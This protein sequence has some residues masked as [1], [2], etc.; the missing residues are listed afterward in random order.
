MQ[1]NPDARPR[2][3]E[4][5]GDQPVPE[6]LGERVDA[7]VE[8]LL[9]GGDPDPRTFE[10]GLP[11]PLRRDLHEALQ[12]ARWVEQTVSA[13]S[14][15]QMER[16][17]LPRADGIRAGAGAGS[18]P[19]E[20]P[21]GQRLGDYEI[22]REVGRGGMGV[23]FEARQ[24][25]LGRR[26]ALKILPPGLGWSPRALE[27][28]RREARAA[29]SLHHPH[30]IPVYDFGEHEG[31]YYFS[32]AFID[33]WSLSSLSRTPE[34]PTLPGRG[35]DG[36]PVRTQ[37]WPPAVPAYATPA[38]FRFVAR[39][40]ADAARAVH[41]AH[42]HGII[43]RDL[44]PS[45]LL[46]DSE[47]QVWIADFGLSR[48]ATDQSVTLSGQ[49]VGTLS[50]MSPEQAASDRPVDQ[51]TDVYGLGATLYELLTLQPPFFARS[52]QEVLRA[53]Q[54]RDPVRPARLNP[55][56]PRDLETITLKALEKDPARRYPSAA[57]LADDLERFLRDLPIRARR[58]GPLRRAAKFLRRQRLVATVALVAAVGLAAAAVAI[59]VALSRKRQAEQQLRIAETVGTQSAQVIA[60][61]GVRDFAEGELSQAEEK[62]QAAAAIVSKLIQV[63]TGT[64]TS[65][66]DLSAVVDATSMA[67][68]FVYQG[69]I[70]LA[71]QTAESQR[72]AAQHFEMALRFVPD[73]LLLRSLK[74]LTA[75]PSYEQ[76]QAIVRQL[77]GPLV[78]HDWGPFAGDAFLALAQVLEHQDLDAARRMVDRA[79]EVDPDNLRAVAYAGWL[80]FRRGDYERA[81]EELRYPCDLQPQN[82]IP[83]L[84]RA[85]VYAAM[86]SFDLALDD[87]EHVLH[88]SPG[89]AQAWYEKLRLIAERAGL[90]PQGGASPATG[91]PPAAR[92]ELL[93]T[94]ERMLEAVRP[95]DFLAY[96]YLGLA[97]RLVDRPGDALAA[98]E[99][100]A[101]LLPDD[102]QGHKAARVWIELGREY[103]AI[104]RE[105][106]A[107]RAFDRALRACPDMDFFL[108]RAR[109]ATSRQ[110]LDLAI[111]DLTEAIRR[112]RRDAPT[113]LERARLL[114]RT[115]R[116]DEALRDIEAALAMDPQASEAYLL[117]SEIRLEQDRLE[118]A[119]TML[120]ALVRHRPERPIG[121]RMR[122][123]AYARLGR[124]AEALADLDA[125]RRFGASS[126]DLLEDRLAVFEALGDTEQA[127]EAAL[128]LYRTDPARVAYL[129]SAARALHRSGRTDE[130]LDLCSR[131]LEQVPNSVPV[132]LLRAEL[133]ASA[134][135]IPEAIDDVLAA[136]E[137]D[138]LDG[139]PRWYAAALLLYGAPPVPGGAERA[140]ALLAQAPPDPRTAAWRALALR[141]AGDLD[142]AIRAA[143]AVRPDHALEVAAV[144]AWHAARSG[145]HDEARAILEQAAAMP[146]ADQPW[147]RRLL[148]DI[149]DD[150]HT[151]DPATPEPDRAGQRAVETNENTQE[152]PS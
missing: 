29:G 117:A 144:R 28:F 133:Y 109:F 128:R 124:R 38:Y 125:A 44:K 99:Q 93:E 102:A 25:S 77:E 50:Y 18:G 139:V 111:H 47:G 98:L 92:N 82:P 94:Y 24:L 97:H 2:P 107:W 51:R 10:A 19:F 142:A 1:H 138:P 34:A 110:K 76:V 141:A 33:G 132:R 65:P 74:L 23:V 127:A 136:I 59:G 63:T 13:V 5:G 57:A 101:S 36:R 8:A 17:A 43:H 145:R 150:L 45:N 69:L 70:N 151:D 137:L 55:R 123:R 78:G 140:L 72:L 130:A 89:D 122:A 11:E 54:D 90:D 149:R 64:Q 16:S 58:A 26:V 88:L 49:L 56:I 27:R 60:G 22:I 73:N 120:D 4:P 6:P 52:P 35:E 148:A 96:L 42:D 116:F 41:H 71:R 31:T 118:D 15:E 105:A 126:T 87:V 83:F 30:I 37:P 81:L 61:A 115:Q 95:G 85:R 9:R 46:V 121:Y 106:D 152:P 53:I 79:R 7:F 135:R 80:S 39:T 14:R 75:N 84:W 48:L 20:V 134:A 100:A 143:E 147:A 103:A 68:P 129:R 113:L 32:M 86:R 12:A 112:G 108:A 119:L 21:A 62:F 131:Y 67:I 40:I 66:G 146:G 91:V 104:G 3:E 114:R